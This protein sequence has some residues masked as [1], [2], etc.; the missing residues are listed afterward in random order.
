MILPFTL[1]TLSPLAGS[2]EVAMSR[3]RGIPSTPAR[4]TLHALLVS[5]VRVDE[6]IAGSTTRGV[7]IATD[8]ALLR[9][10]DSAHSLLQ[11]D[12]LDVLTHGI[13]HRGV[14]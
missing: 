5:G 7:P 14:N 3:S 12:D 6:S 13:A 10:R 2:E 9:C 4:I 11:D 8:P 1:T